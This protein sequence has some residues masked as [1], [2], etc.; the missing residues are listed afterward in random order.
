MT[1][2]Q[3][4]D[5]QSKNLAHIGFSICNQPATQ[6]MGNPSLVCLDIV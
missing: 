1:L 4:Y 3:D 6:W 2:L 5:S